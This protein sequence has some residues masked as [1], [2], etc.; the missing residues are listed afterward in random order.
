LE[1]R[2][3]KRKKTIAAVP[4]LLAVRTAGL[5]PCGVLCELANLDGTMARPPQIVSFAEKHAS[6]V[7]TVEDLVKYRRAGERKAN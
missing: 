2:A 5:K 6:P 7:V 1:A 4:V 3:I